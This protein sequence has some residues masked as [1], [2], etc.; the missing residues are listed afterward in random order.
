MNCIT[1]G[2][3]TELKVQSSPPQAVKDVM[4][5]VAGILGYEQDW[6]TALKMMKQPNFYRQFVDFDV[7]NMNQN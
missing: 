2:A 7:D 6:P 1:K 5:K 4:I 3:I